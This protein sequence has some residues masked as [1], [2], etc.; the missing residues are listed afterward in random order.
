MKERF[1]NVKVL[2]KILRALR[3]YFVFV[4]ENTM[5]QV[6]AHRVISVAKFLIRRTTRLVFVIL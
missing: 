6:A 5:K 4:N 3:I 2:V 1:N